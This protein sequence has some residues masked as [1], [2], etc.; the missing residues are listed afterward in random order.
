MT[1]SSWW[2]HHLKFLCVPFQ[3]R[4]LEVVTGG[5][6]IDPVLLRAWLQDPQLLMVL[7]GERSNR[8]HLDLVC[9]NPTQNY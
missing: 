8:R 1:M 2:I 3:K 4:I 9:S 6:G 5:E 7:G